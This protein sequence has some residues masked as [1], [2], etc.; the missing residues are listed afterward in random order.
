MR[1]KPRNIW[2]YLP[3]LYTVAYITLTS[4]RIEG[5]ALPILDYVRRRRISANDYLILDDAPKEFA[6]TSDLLP[7]L[8]V[9][10]PARGPDNRVWFLASRNFYARCQAA[11]FMDDLHDEYALFEPPSRN[12]GDLTTTRAAPSVPKPHCQFTGAPYAK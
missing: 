2:S 4:R 12:R 9:C 10:D 5:C 1:L 7:R 6:S 3:L 8:V 11:K